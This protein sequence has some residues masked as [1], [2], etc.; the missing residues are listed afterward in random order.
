[1][2]KVLVVEDEPTLLETLE[3]NLTRQGYVVCT[4]SDGRTALEKARQERPDTIVLD[5]M[6]P[7]LDGFEVCRIL[8]QEMSVPVL[9]LT[10]RDDE[11]DKIVGLEVGADDYMTKP[12]SMRELLARVKAMLRRERLIRE[13]MAAKGETAAEDTLVFGDLSIDPVRREALRRGK[14]L[15]LKPREYELLLFLAR[16]RGIVLSRDLILERVWGW[17]YNGGSRTVDVHVR[18]L[19][20][21]IESDPANPIRIVTVRTVGYRFEG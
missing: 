17:D 13:E 4:A 10:A 2:S 11:V 8:R 5:I 3:Y 12:F 15:N 1:M 9:M 7:G 14:P 19:R 6:L 16:N 21:K 18:W 20:E